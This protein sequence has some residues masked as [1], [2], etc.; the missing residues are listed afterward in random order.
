MR[1]FRVTEVVTP[2]GFATSTVCDANGL[3]VD[4]IEDY[5]HSLR[6]RPCSSNTVRSYG[7]HL[8][9]LFTWFDARAVH[10][11]SVDFSDLADFMGTYRLGVHPLPK[12]GGGHRSVATMRAAAAAIR[13]FYEYHRVESG[14]GPANL[15]LSREMTRPGRGNPNHFLAHIEARRETTQVNRLS[16]GL[17]VPEPDFEII[18]FETDFSRMLAACHTTRDRLA[19]SGFYDLGLRIGQVCG[20]RHGD[21]DVRRR[22]LTVV[23]RENNINGA[24]S[25]RRGSFL[26]PEGHKRFFD[27]YRD[28]LLNEVLARGIE[29]DYVFVNLK[30]HPVGAPVSYSNLAQQVRAIGIRS[31]VGPVHPHML[32]HTHATAL[33]KAGWTAVEIAKRLGQTSA[34]SAEPYIHL[35]NSDIEN[36]LRETEHLV[37]GGLAHEGN[38]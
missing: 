13:E 16:S 19:L 37:W 29:S 9:A 30:R 28:Y 18:N 1:K 26:V 20:L 27:F 11:E 36:R 22:M 2:S 38:R 24:L 17:P 25:K 3:P 31:G 33:A 14:R 35:A 23:R 21:L 10:W 32:R 5:L 4:D 15:R 34:T 7:H 8:A 6:A 12:R